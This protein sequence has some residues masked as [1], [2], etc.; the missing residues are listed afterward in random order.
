MTYH[1]IG[2]GPQRKDNFYADISSIKVLRPPRTI[3]KS[4]RKST[5]VAAPPVPLPPPE[6]A[7]NSKGEGSSS[8]PHT[9]AP[10]PEHAT[11]PKHDSSSSPAKHR[12]DDDTDTERRTKHHGEKA[13]DKSQ[14]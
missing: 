13:A 4:P 2:K 7:N 11:A 10:P 8:F 12:L 9:A 1:F 6:D 14:K 3:S 5:T